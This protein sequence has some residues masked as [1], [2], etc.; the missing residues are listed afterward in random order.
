MSTN[1][2]INKVEI[3]KCKIDECLE[4][5]K[6]IIDKTEKRSD[7]KN[8]INDP[9]DYVYEIIGTLNNPNITHFPGTKLFY[10]SESITT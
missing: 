4:I 8:W 1:L 7:F 5:A 6:S 3:P 10:L 2:I 9:L